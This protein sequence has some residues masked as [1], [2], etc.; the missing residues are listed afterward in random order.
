MADLTYPETAQ[1]VTVIGA[2][3]TGTEQTPVQSTGDGALHVNLRNADGTAVEDGLFVSSTLNGPLVGSQTIISTPTFGNSTAIVSVNG[4][5]DPVQSVV[6]EGFDGANWYSIIGISQVSG[7]LPV[8]YIEAPP[9]TVVYPIGGWSEIRV[10][11]LNG[12]AGGQSIS[13]TIQVNS[14][15]NLIQP[16]NVV[17]SALR[18]A[19]YIKTS[20]GS[21]IEFGQATMANSLPVTVA[22]NQS[23]IPVSGTITANA[24][25][26]TMAVSAASLPLPTGASTAALQTT[27]N[28]SLS[29]I[30][31]KLVQLA[32]SGDRLKVELP[33]GGG[34]LT[35]AELRAS[36]VPVSGTVAVS[37]SFALDTTASAIKTSVELIDDAI[38]TDN[39]GFTDGTTKLSMAGYFYDESAGPTPLTENDAAAARININRAQI[40][41]IEDGTTRGRYVTVSASNALKVDGSAVTQPISAASLPLPTGAAADATLTGGTARTKITDGTNNVAVKAASTAPATTDPALVV[42]MSPNDGVLFRGIASTFNTPGRAGTAGQKILSLHNATGSSVTVRVKRV[43]VDLET[44]VVKAVTVPS[45]IVRLWKVTV[46]P[47]NGTSLTKN[48]IGGTTTSSAS[49]TVLGDASADGTGSATTLTA[50]LPAGTI[51]AQEYAPRVI[52]A[53]GY[54]MAD[55]LELRCDGDIVLGALE[56]VVVFLDYTA[57]GQNPTTDRWLATIEW[58]EH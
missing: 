47:T 56:G 25:S 44:T 28:S 57:A 58:T 53:A 33:A 4:D 37:N 32:L 55:K 43:V 54:E 49:V 18:T 9:D 42:A 5:I 38:V 26:G 35:D 11:A 40:N 10:T 7:G 14:G 22:S 46:L 15:A 1:L 24:G 45:P 21:D 3:A 19:S 27:G 48:K 17:P 2:D 20:S 12:V 13:A 34:G 50:T 51:L 29:S 39:S 23:A 52:T 36:P 8:L 16:F 41:V 6:V 30:D 31:T